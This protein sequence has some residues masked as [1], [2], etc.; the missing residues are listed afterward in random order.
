MGEE[1]K[2]AAQIGDIDA[3]YKIIEDNPSILK[4]IDALEFV[5]T[6]LHTAASFGQTD[7]AIEMLSLMPSFGRKLDPRGY[8]PLHLALSNEQEDTVKLLI[9]Y[10]P[11]LI[12]VRSRERITPL[13][14][15]AAQTDNV[16]LLS[17]FLLACPT[18]IKEV[19]IRGETAVFPAFK[20]LMGWLYRT[21]NKKILDWKDNEG[22]TVLHI[23]AETGQVEVVK[24][25]AKELVHLDIRNRYDMTALDIVEERKTYLPKN[26]KMADLLQEIPRFI[27]LA[28]VIRSQAAVIVDSRKGLTD[29]VRN[30]YLVVTILLV[31]ASF[32]AVLSPPGGG[33]ERKDDDTN[34]NNTSL[35]QGGYQYPVLPILFTGHVLEILKDIAWKGKCV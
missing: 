8:S 33:W 17:E 22:S 32:Q 35:D 5:E 21:G 7:F 12:Q 31:T 6:P 9:R 30:A 11:K 1:M 27:D 34:N 16:D 13:H 10:D 26:F 28:N 15:V 3:F 20:V 18:A 14:Y 25:L 2:R 24:I 4:Q 19:T 29:D 23:A